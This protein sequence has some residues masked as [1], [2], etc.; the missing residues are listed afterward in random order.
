MG[1]RQGRR[2]ARAR[3]PRSTSATTS[4]TSRAPAPPARVSVSVLTGGCTREELRGGRHR[5]RPRRPRRLPGLARRPPARPPARGARGAT[6]ASSGSVLVAFSGGADSRVPAGRRGPRARRRPGGRRDRRTPTRCRRPSATRPAAF[7]DEPRRPGADAADP[8]D[9]PRGLP[10]QRRRPL[11]LLQGRAARR[12]RAAGRRARARR[13]SPPAPTPTTP[14]PA[15][16]P[17]SAPP[18]SAARHPAARRRASPRSRS[19]RPRGAGACRPGTSRP[20]PACPSRVAYGIEVTP[21]RLAR[22]ERAEAAVRAAARRRP[23]LACATSGCATWATGPRSRS[24]P[25]AAGRCADGAARPRVLAAVREAGFAEAVV[26]PRGFRSGSMNE[27]ARPSASAEPVGAAP[28]PDI[29][30][31]AADAQHTRERGQSRADWQGEVVR[32]RQG[33]RLPVP[34]GR[35]ATSTCAPRRC[36]TGSPTAQGRHPRRVRHRPGPQGRPGAPGADARPARP[37]SRATSREAQRKKPEDMATIVEDLIRLLDDVGEAYRR[38]RH[39]DATR[40]QADRQAAARARRRAGALGLGPG[41][42]TVRGRAA[43]R[44]CDQHERPTRPTSTA[45]ADAQAELRRVERHHDADEPADHPGQLEQ[46]SRS[47]RRRWPARARAR[48]AGSVASSD[49]LA[50]AWASPAVRPS[51]ASASRP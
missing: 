17:A 30:W 36:P 4:T 50:S 18:P 20:P 5:R 46:S 15:S 25:A 43:R 10:R 38:G 32:R 51:S 34:G 26:D 1:R 45:A 22:V 39:P 24:T 40:R 14:S 8:R 37:R 35:P 21:H 33:L 23:G 47:G 6:C 19:G 11:L 49:S 2:A 42:A 27:C 31:R 44:G 28:T 48:R 29:G 9:G 7:A 13:T 41:L 12:A 16:G 3:A